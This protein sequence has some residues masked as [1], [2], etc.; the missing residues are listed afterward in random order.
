MLLAGRRPGTD[1]LAAHFGVADKA[2]IPIAGEAMLS[3]VVRALVD[4]PAIGRLIVLTQAGEALAAHSDTRWLADHPKL[5]FEASGGSVSQGIADALARHA[6]DYP[7]LVVTADNPLLSHATIDAFLAGAA[8]AD[9]AAGVVERRTLL[10]RYPQSKRTWLKFRGGA[11]SGANLFWLA[12]PQVAPVL[13]LWR[14]IEQER[15]RGRAVIGAFGPLMLAGV[16]LRLLTLHR[17]IA[18]AG[19]RFGLG[20]RAIV[21]P[22]AEACIDVDSVAD[23]AL[24]ERIL[25]G[26]DEES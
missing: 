15:K 4:H 26:R 22:V 18:L 19:R 3:R 8:G 24:V 1:P 10:S 5:D 12:G 14:T 6:G 25:K 17:A 16:A 20:A 2:L 7:F 23:H 13:A 9:L 11:Y 21:I